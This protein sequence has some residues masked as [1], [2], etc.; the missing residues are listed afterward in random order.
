MKNS[1]LV[2]QLMKRDVSIT[3]THVLDNSKAA[4]GG[5]RD[6]NFLKFLIDNKLLVQSEGILKRSKLDAP[7]E[8]YLENYK[9]FH[10]ESD[11]HFLCRTI[12]QDEL[13]SL[14][15]DSMSSM[16]IG[17]MDILRANSNYDIVTGDF[18]AIIDIGLTPA[19]NYFRGLTD[20]RV[21]NYLITSYFD[22]YMDDIIFSVFTRSSNED[23][24]EALKDYEEG[25]KQYAPNSFAYLESR[26]FDPKEEL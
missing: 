25:F 21:K 9:K 12:I 24:L 16:D 20:L 15:I 26:E 5:E 18:S 23:F 10:F 14:G 4:S 17:N 19:R 8:Y 13:K 3:L 1:H 22:D 2:D 7:E 6:V 11:R